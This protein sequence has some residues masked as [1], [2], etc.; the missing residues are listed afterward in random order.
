MRKLPMEAKSRFCLELS[1]IVPTSFS[2]PFSNSLSASYCTQ[3]KGEKES[4][5]W[6]M[7]VN[8]RFHPVTKSRSIAEKYSNRVLGPHVVCAVHKYI[9]MNC[10]LLKLTTKVFTYVPLNSKVFEPRKTCST[11]LLM[12]ILGCAYFAW[13]MGICTCTSASYYIWHFM[14]YKVFCGDSLKYFVYKE[15]L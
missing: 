15:E 5:L 2:P 6:F 10:I 4:V 12:S 3:K 1:T 7:W 8:Q 11:N 13:K 14:M 9:A